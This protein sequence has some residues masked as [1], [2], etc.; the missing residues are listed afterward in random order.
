MS[1][2]KITY[3]DKEAVNPPGERRNQVWDADMNQIKSVMGNHADLIDDLKRVDSID[4]STGFSVVDNDFTAEADWKWTIDNIQYTNIV[5]VEINDIPYSASGKR[6]IDYIIPNDS[7]SFERVSGMEVDETGLLAPPS[8]PNNG[9]YITYFIV[10]DSSVGYPTSPII[11]E[12]YVS[13]I[14]RDGWDDNVSI[15][16]NVFIPAPTSK[17]GLLIVYNAGLNSLDGVDFTNVQASY[18]G[19]E[20][21]IFNR[22][23]SSIT[24]NHFAAV[25]AGQAGFRL[26]N[27]LPLIVPD[28]GQVAFNNYNHTALTQTWKNWDDAY[29]KSET[30]DLLDSKLD[31]STYNQHF[32]GVYVTLAALNAAHPTASVGDYAQVNEAGSTDV[33]NYN[34]D[35]EDSVWVA[36]GGTGGAANTDALP[37]GSTNLYFTTGRALTAAPA[38]TATTIAAINHG[39]TAKT[40][41]VDADEVTGQNSATSFSLIRTVWSDVWTYIKSKADTY[42]QPKGVRITNATTTGSYAIDWAAADVWELTLT[43]AT[44]LTD[45]NL[46]TGTATKVI[47]FL[48]TGAFAWT[49]PAYWDALPSSQAYNGAVWNHVVISCIKGTASSERVLYSNE[50]I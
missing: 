43:G 30:D 47:E 28:K 13:K 29:T 34:W 36:G 31:A 21:I 25:S 44:T 42:Y 38:E 15:G 14:D 39:A 23:G 48:I 9:I 11:G 37:E 46:P 22:T 3:E 33:I 2:E 10:D 50:P 17:Q 40:V 12:P 6:R 20:Y 45:T 18:N 49:P 26:Q 8:L 35:N 7:N 1:A 4:E 16:D 24:L 27:E 32:K 5:P 19:K 41:L